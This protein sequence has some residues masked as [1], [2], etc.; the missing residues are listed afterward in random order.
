[1]PPIAQ[2]VESEIAS[3]VP[4]PP[5]ESPDYDKDNPIWGLVQ[6]VEEVDLAAE[7]EHYMADSLQ[8]L[9][10]IAS[11][12][13]H[14]PSGDQ[15]QVRDPRQQDN[16]NDFQKQ[17]LRSYTLAGTRLVRGFA[18]AGAWSGSFLQVSHAPTPSSPLLGADGVYRGARLDLFLRIGDA[19]TGD[20]LLPMTYN[21]RT[22]RF[23]VEI[24]GVDAGEV[25]AGLGPKGQAAAERGR[26]TDVRDHQGNPVEGGALVFRPDLVRGRYDELYGAGF[27]ETR[28]TAAQQGRGVEMID[29]AP[30]HTMHPTRP[31]HL[32]VAFVSDDGARWDSAG[33]QNHHYEFSMSLRGWRHFL[34]V[35]ESTNPH[36]GQGSL[37]YRN[38]FSNY[39]GHEARRRQ[40]FGDG[41][42]TE[43]GRDL[44]AWSFD[45]NGQKPPTRSQEA[46][47]AVDYMDLHIL[48]PNAIIGLHRHRDNQEAFMVL[49][50]KALM[51]V[52]DWAKHVGRER[53]FEIRTMRPGDLALIKGGQ[54]HALANSLDE[55][56]LL[57]MFGGYD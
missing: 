16:R 37:E 43:L 34:S 22:A 55:N 13:L 48:R 15:W 3:V 31:L 9:L 6:A 38:L 26:G 45:A 2:I 53:A 44:P 8:H 52:G 57:F 54:M 40:V 18:A 5:G 11:V 28:R 4:T 36:G 29:H 23:E 17:N 25:E 50:G 41:V 39:F 14:G 35:G 32:E 7:R 20:A 51:V 30:D 19:N 10:P 27:T 46:F 42:T 33:G 1:M 24:W 12:A 49:E 21:P 47:L 56:V